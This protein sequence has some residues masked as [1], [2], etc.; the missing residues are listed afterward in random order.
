VN[1][2]IIGQP[3]SRAQLLPTVYSRFVISVP[4]DPT[5]SMLFRSSFSN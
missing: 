4:P 3:L 5:H 1:T 2:R